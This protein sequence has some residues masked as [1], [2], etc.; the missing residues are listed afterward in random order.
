ML[1]MNHNMLMHQEEIFK[2]PKKEYTLPK[3]QAFL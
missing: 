3:V 2:D 1:W